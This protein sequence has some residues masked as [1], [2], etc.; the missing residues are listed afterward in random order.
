MTA[1]TLDDFLEC[2]ETE[3]KPSEAMYEAACDW[4]T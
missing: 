1:V 2:I 4:G 3:T